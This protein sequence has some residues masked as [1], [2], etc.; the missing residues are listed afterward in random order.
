MLPWATY[1]ARAAA[2]VDEITGR[3]SP[4]PAKDWRRVEE[5]LLLAYRHMVERHEPRREYLREG[6][7]FSNPEVDLGPGRS[8]KGASIARIH[9]TVRINTPIEQVFDYVSTPGNW[10]EWHPSSLGVSGATDHSLEP[11][12]KVTE[13]YLV[14]GRRG[15][16]VWTVRERAAPSRWV[17][18]GRTEGGGGETITYTLT[19]HAGGTTFEREFVYS[20]PNPLLALLDRLVLRRRIATESAEALRRL[21]AT[22]ERRAA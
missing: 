15:R 7:N 17:I 20:M 12:E 13:E 5:N 9:K 11:D 18:D 4:D 19:P 22:L 21:K 8:W 6:G 16:V 2:F 1:R 10:P 14:A 3:R